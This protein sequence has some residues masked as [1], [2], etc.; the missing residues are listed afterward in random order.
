AVSLKLCRN[1][2]IRDVSFLM[3]GHFAI[4]ATGVDN[5]TIDNIKIDTNRDGIDVDSCRHVRMSNVAVNSPADDAIVIK[6]THALGFARDTVDM[7]ITNCE[8]TGFEN[9]SFLNG[10][11]K[12]R[13]EPPNSNGPTGRIKIGT[14]SEGGFKNITI[15]NCVFDHSRGLALETV[16][17]AA[18]ED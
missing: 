18:I 14:E 13:V 3:A 15:S 4:L 6:G 5:L 9:G 2:L 12:P 1:V 16:D 8:V 11:Y 7:T 17:G 10:T